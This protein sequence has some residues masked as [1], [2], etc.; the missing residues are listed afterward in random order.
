MHPSAI[1]SLAP[2]AVEGI[3]DGKLIAAAATEARVRNSLLL[4]A[5]FTPFS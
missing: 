5:I 1:R 4:I 2:K 3:S